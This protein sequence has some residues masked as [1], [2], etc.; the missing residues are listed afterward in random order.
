MMR[1]TALL[2]GI[3]FGLGLAVSGMLDPAK[4]LGFLDVF[5][6]WDP[7]LAFVMGGA[8]LVS[9]PAFQLSRRRLRPLLAP[10][11]DLP[12]FTHI[13][14]RLLA[15]AAVFGLGWGLGGFCPGPAVAALSSLK[16]PVVGFIVT[17]AAG[18]WLADMLVPARHT[19]SASDAAAVVASSS[20]L[21]AAAKPGATHAVSRTHPA[22]P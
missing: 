5:G 3:V 22:P 14:G 8:I 21:E 15:G 10:R 6:P 1:V 19:K 2:C 20:L 11:F 16:W 9:M 18:M 4:V 12:T 13:D 7:T 17:M